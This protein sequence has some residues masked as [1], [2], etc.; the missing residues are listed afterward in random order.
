MTEIPSQSDEREAPKQPL[1]GH[2]VEL[3]RRLLWSFAAMGAGTLVCFM[4]SDYIYGLLV[5]PLAE[6][7][8]P[9]DTRR[10]IYTGLTEAFVTYIKV[11][12]FAGV[13]LTF[14]VLMIQLWRFIAPGLYKKE[15]DIFL[16]FLLA[17]PVLFFLGGAC[18]YFVVM[19]VAWHFLLSFESAGGNTV[20]PVQLEARVG[21]YLD[22]VMLL[23]F[24]FGFCFELPVLLTLLGRAGI[25]TAAGLASKRRYAIVAIFIVAAVITPPDV[26]SQFMLAVPLMGLYE[27]SIFLVRRNEKSR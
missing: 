4:F 26:L 22:L 13:F 27:L 5:R 24:A 19:P 1:S 16:P 21:E 14:P 18:A 6:A 2:L 3:R 9:G 7:M 17:T 10:L 11:A 25:V 12:F 23:I 8:G 15:K 20:L